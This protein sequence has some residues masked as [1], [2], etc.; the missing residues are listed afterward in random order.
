LNFLFLPLWNL[1]ASE[2]KYETYKIITSDYILWPFLFF[3]LCSIKFIIIVFQEEIYSLSV[4]RCWINDNGKCIHNY[5]TWCRLY[6][7]GSLC[8][9]FSLHSAS[10]QLNDIQKYLV[11]SRSVVMP[12]M[13]YNRVEDWSEIICSILTFHIHFF[14][15]IVLKIHSLLLFLAS[16]KKT[17]ILFILL[18]WFAFVFTANTHLQYEELIQNLYLSI[19][20]QW[21]IEKIFIKYI[22]ATGT[23]GYTVYDNS[24]MYLIWF[25]LFSFVFIIKKSTMGSYLFPQMSYMPV[26]ILYWYTELISL[27]GQ[28]VADSYRF[29]CSIFD[30]IFINIKKAVQRFPSFW[31]TPQRSTK[32]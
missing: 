21:K 17:N 27:S 4:N 30:P 11:K 32:L 23:T 1:F 16:K 12:A 26:P 25:W 24:Y 22:L 9:L 3:E 13:W 10:Q 20:I 14:P 28:M 5:Y 6:I 18:T 2:S 29:I 15:N 8:S 7:R 31:T 19:Y